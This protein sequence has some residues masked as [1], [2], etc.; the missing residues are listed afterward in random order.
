MELKNR[1][2]GLGIAILGIFSVCYGQEQVSI[3]GLIKDASNGEDL[4]GASVYVKGQPVGTTTNIYGFYSLTLPK[5]E[6]DL[7]YSFIGYKDLVKHL[8]LTT[9]QTINIELNTNSAVLT[10]VVIS[11]TRE[12]EN[13]KSNEVGVEQLDV[14]QVEKIPVVMGEKDIVKTIQLLPGIKSAGEGSSGFFVR[15]GSSDQ[16][17]I[18]LDEAPVYNAAHAL[19]FF[20]VFN[21]DAIKNVKMYKGIAPTSFGGRLSSVMDI[22]MKDGNQKKMG[23]SGGLGLISSRLTVEAPIKKDKGA[24]VISGRRTYADVIL[25]AVTDDYD[26][27]SLYFYDLNLK[28]NY[29][30]GEKD[31]LYLSGY[32]G[33]DEF[34]LE[35]AFTN[36][37]GNSTGTIRWNHVFNNKW[38]SNTSF[39]YSNY[40]Y[41]LEASSIHLITNIEDYNF[42]T[43]FQYYYSNAS[44]INFGFNVIKHNFVPGKVDYNDDARTDYENERG[45]LEY[46]AYIGHDTKLG[47]RLSMN[48][49]ARLSAFSVLGPGDHYTFDA[50]GEAIDTIS[51]SSNEF[52]KTYYG[53]E[54]R[55][56]LNYALNEYSSVKMGVGRNY[57]YMHLLSNSTG[58]TPLDVW[59]P[60]SELIEPQYADQVSLGYFRNLFNN[61]FEFSSELYYKQ[62]NNVI[63]Y[64]DGAD[65][66]LNP[67]IEGQL[68]YGEGE[69]YGIEMLFKKKTGRL[70]GWISYTL[71]R[72]ENTFEE[73]NGGDAFPTSQD[74]THDISIVG[75]YKVNDKWSLSAN[76]IYLSGNAVTLP[77]SKYVVNNEVLTYYDGRNNGRMP[78]THRLDIGATYTFPKKKNYE[79]S[80]NFSVYNAYGRYN[81]YSIAFESDRYNPLQ[82][83]IV[84]TSLF[85]VVPSITY[86][87]K[88]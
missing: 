85:S 60:S 6:Y 29:K 76:W 22:Q 2:L 4:I 57:Q 88:F 41:D 70:T 49:G 24:F 54:P 31:R 30:L 12:D 27:V 20:S 84:Q 51:Y 16:N 59:Y 43:D 61:A 18:L 39:I 9:D 5:G 64:K 72:S 15:G 55:L 32:F 10:E 21:S 23:V 66:F 69:A 82:T 37:Y 13:L 62:M 48:Y 80:L 11:D 17:L 67:L 42:K 56:V 79:S 74:R 36:N 87:F 52:I 8:N 50:E 7:V 25:K 34:G 46:A 68:E 3:S 38:F 26:D 47:A 81:P 71:S 33:R 40:H 63:A 78:S 65:I 45:A 19:G 58:G 83:S 77:S 35:D 44:K 53:L 75:I 86:N 73:L 28:A 14:K 1:L